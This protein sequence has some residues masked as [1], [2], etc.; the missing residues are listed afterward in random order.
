MFSV[1]SCLCIYFLPIF[2][3]SLWATVEGL[4]IPPTLHYL[5]QVADQL[6]IFDRL[7][8]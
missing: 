2:A 8:Q 6:A 7:A 3:I 5:R 4:H 1:L